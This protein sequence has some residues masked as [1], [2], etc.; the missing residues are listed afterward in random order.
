MSLRHVSSLLLCDIETHIE[1]K[2]TKWHRET[3]VTWVIDIISV[4]NMFVKL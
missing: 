1:I 2:V 4:K 3:Y